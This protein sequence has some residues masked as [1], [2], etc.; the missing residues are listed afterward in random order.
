M[1]YLI[2]HAMD[3]ESY[4]GSWSDVEILES[5][6]EKVKKLGEYIKDNL[7][8]SRIYSSDIRR[9]YQTAEIIAKELNMEV[10]IDK[11][12]REQNKGTLT[13]KLKSTLSKKDKEL[14]ENQQ[15]DTLFPEGETLIDLYNRIKSYLKEIKKYEDNSLI[16]THR[17]VIN[18][19]YYILNDIPLDMDKKR[20]DV[21]HL[22]IHELDINN[23]VIR[24]IKWL[25][26]LY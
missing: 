5:E 26:E 21:D 11:N 19:I 17:G 4:V 12:L 6:K 7:N 1:L 23:K 16:V 24:R 13:G 2:R 3:D 22:S 25:K 15:I 14:L 8:I 10:H 18:M 20:F 9:A